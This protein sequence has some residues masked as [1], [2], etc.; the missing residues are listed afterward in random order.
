MTEKRVAHFA[1]QI[2][3]NVCRRPTQEPACPLLSSGLHSGFITLSSACQHRHFQNNQLPILFP[4]DIHQISL[5][6]PIWQNSKFSI[7]S[8][9]TV[10]S[11]HKQEPKAHSM[12]SWLSEETACRWPLCLQPNRFLSCLIFSRCSIPCTA[13]NI[14]LMHLG[15]HPLFAIANR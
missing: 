6:P 8:E 10:V 2:R 11:I 3:T 1:F 5:V 14:N 4:S 7:K 9:Q 15:F 12:H 13:C